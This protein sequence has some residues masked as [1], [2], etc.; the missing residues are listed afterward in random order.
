M[1]CL[2]CIVSCFLLGTSYAQNVGI[3][4]STPIA[5]LHVTDSNVVFSADGPPPTP[6]GNL[7]FPNTGRG[8][9]WYAD[10]AAFRA[11]MSMFG[12]WHK[13]SIG[14]YSFAGGVGN[15][16]TGAAATS[17][18]SNNNSSGF[19]SF[20]AGGGNYATNSFSTAFGQFSNSR[21]YGSFA[22]GVSV[23]STGYASAAFGNETFATNQYASAFGQYT[24]ASGIGSFA[25]GQYSVANNLYTVAMGYNSIANGTYSSSFGDRSVSDG[26]ASFSAGTESK[27]RGFGSFALGYQVAANGSAAT[28]IGYATQ[29]NSESSLAMGTLNDTIV[30]VGAF[31]GDRPVLMI[32]NGTTNPDLTV[33]RSNA[34][35]VFNSGNAVHQGYTKLGNL[36]GDNAPAI[37]MKEITSAV[38]SSVDGGSV[39]IPHGLDRSKIIGFSAIVNY[40]TGDVIPGFRATSGFEFSIA[41]DNANIFIYNIAGNSANITNKPVKIV[42]TYRQ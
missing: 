41:Y 12:F 16:T 23:Q 4:T 35:T 22:A 15:L 6:A 9:I 10:K 14:T 3:G 17:F 19:N 39:T 11:G 1:K 13:D 20:A 34:F 31:G 28:A 24:Q 7:S 27:A 21:G 2:L 29:A 32:G 5:R 26:F 18:G 25:A 42:I 33:N 37:K 38:T 36:P 8:L 30:A 40:G